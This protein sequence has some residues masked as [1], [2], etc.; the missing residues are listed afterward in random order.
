MSRDCIRNPNCRI[1]L[2]AQGMKALHDF[3]QQHPAVNIDPFLAGANDRLRTYFYEVQRSL[4]PWIASPL[5]VGA[6]V[7]VAR[8]AANFESHVLT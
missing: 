5:G 3:L 4:P 7:R 1:L 6:P 8:P 2:V